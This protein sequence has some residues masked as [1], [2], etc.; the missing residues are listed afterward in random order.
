MDGPKP[1]RF[2]IEMAN[3]GDASRYYECGGKCLRL[4]DQW[5]FI[6]AASGDMRDGRHYLIVELTP[7]AGAPRNIVTNKLDR[8][9]QRVVHSHAPN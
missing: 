5:Y 1:L 9:L 2:E 6:S 8:L 7:E 4:Q 3:L